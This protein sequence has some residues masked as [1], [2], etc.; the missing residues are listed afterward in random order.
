MSNDRVAVSGEPAVIREPCA[1]MGSRNRD[2]NIWLDRETLIYRFVAMPMR[3][4]KFARAMHIWRR[5]ALLAATSARRELEGA[6]TL[7]LD[8]ETR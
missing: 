8:Y 5:R 4:T 1:V 3:A 2:Q 6:L 7:F